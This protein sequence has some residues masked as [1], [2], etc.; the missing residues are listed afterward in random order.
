[1][2]TF[3]KIFKNGGHFEFSP[4][5]PKHKNASISLTVRDR[6]HRV[7]EEK[8]WSWSDFF[9]E[10][11]RRT[12]LNNW[13]LLN[14]RQFAEKQVMLQSF[15]IFTMTWRTTLCSKICNKILASASQDFQYAWKFLHPYLALWR[16]GKRSLFPPIGWNTCVVYVCEHLPHLT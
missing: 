11:P 7:C 6:A 15:F 4:K 2:T 10:K 13:N 14:M 8:S 3:Q 5:M 1:M 12:I 9:F 16:D